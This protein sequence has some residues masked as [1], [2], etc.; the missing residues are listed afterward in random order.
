MGCATARTISLEGAGGHLVDVQVDIAQGVV[1]T[2]LVGRPDAA[3]T[4][5]RDRCR[6]ALTNSGFTWPSTRRVTILL[7][8]ADLPK[9]G[10]HFDLAIAVAVLAA[11]GEVPAAALE[12]LVVAGELTLDG[13]LRAVPGILPMGMAT[14]ARGMPRLMVPDSQVDEA[15]LVPGLEVVGVRSLPQVVAL[16][17][18]EPVP[19]APPVP[20]PSGGPLLS[21]RGEHRTDDLDLADVLG[22][23]DARFAL[24]VAAAGGHHLLLSGPKGAG[25]T[26][27]AERLPG[28]LPDLGLDEALELTAVDSLAGGL[29]PGQT[30]VTRPPFRAPHH[31]ATRTSV[32]GGG[33]GRVHPGE[34]S[35]AHHG[36]LLLDEFPLFRGDI[37]DGLREPLE[38]G[39]VTIAR[40]D[41]S[42]T[43][44]AR[45]LVVLACNPCPCG[46][47]HPS[48]LESR[49]TCPETA[50]RTY[51]RKLTGPVID[52]IDITR[53]VTPVP[54]HEARDP[55][56]RPESTAAVRERVTAARSRQRERYDGTA[57]RL[58]ADVSGPALRER[59]PLDDAATE[60]L[61]AQVYGGRLTRRGAT[62]VHRLAWTVA[63]LAGAP[64]PGAEELDTA[65][66]LR[67][68][69]PLLLA[70]LTGRAGA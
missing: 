7:S 60:L 52:R 59:W 41:D 42:A 11:S 23:A 14:A 67:T 1:K 19:S 4:E 58:N 12:G 33:T 3:I 54:P 13:R 17:R 9:R 69:E 55:L 20:P 22:M 2:A 21:W 16:L 10:P 6:A 26:T 46:D 64:R 62:R 48:A 63:D 31:S 53:H 49:C 44:P 66:R 27:L 40:G 37:V 15:V 70:A 18:G 43:F 65:L 24:E 39:E 5:S 47:Y 68:G 25:K 56:A 8:P 51:R 57:W 29:A 28:L 50:R 34:V 35:R 38:S 45:C 36:I 61:D 32:L 30:L